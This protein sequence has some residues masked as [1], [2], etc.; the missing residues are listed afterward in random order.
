MYRGR[1]QAHLTGAAITQDRVLAHFF[2]RGA[3]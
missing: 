1:V 3:A 2:E